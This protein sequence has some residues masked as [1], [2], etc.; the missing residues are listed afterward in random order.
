M[1]DNSEIKNSPDI[2]SVDVHGNGSVFIKWYMAVG[3]DKYIIKRSREKDSG[4][5]KVAT[6]KKKFTSY[7]DESIESEGTYW[8]KI[9]AWKK[10]PEGT[11]PVQ[12]HGEPQ[13]ADVSVIKAPKE[14]TIET[15]GHKDIRFTW[16][17]CEDDIDG[18]V[19]LRRY[20]FMKVPIAIAKVGKD[21][22]EYTDCA[23]VAGQLYHYSV[24]G[25][26]SDETERNTRYGLASGELDTICF[27]TPI[28]LETK[29]KH[30]K[31]VSFSVRLTSGADCY[32]LYKSI[33]ENGEYTE[34][35]R[36]KGLYDLTLSD[37]GEKK[38]KKAFYKLACIKITDGREFTGPLSKPIEIKY[39]F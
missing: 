1:P 30:G 10:M 34:V 12:R 31:K 21:I 2:I 8:Y 6:V 16:N 35:S 13:L 32:A 22:N 20:D 29:R 23:T 15:I 7:L 11:K 33:K 17:K 28:V 39:K 5:Q 24:Q 4:Y 26:I 37:I 27:D 18:Y 38:Q 3:A 14:N 36:T 9:S 25:Y 19:V